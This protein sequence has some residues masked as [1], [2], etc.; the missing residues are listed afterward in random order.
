MICVVSWGTLFSTVIILRTGR[1]GNRGSFPGGVGVFSF[2]PKHA[3]RSAA[4][5]ISLINMHRLV[6]LQD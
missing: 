4:H 3:D 6:L 5:N 2:S 1:L